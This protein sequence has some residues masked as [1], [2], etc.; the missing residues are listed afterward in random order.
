MLLK[1]NFFFEKS[2][3]LC[4]KDRE[5]FKYDKDVKSGGGE[6]FFVSKSLGGP[7]IVVIWSKKA[8]LY[9]PP[10]KYILL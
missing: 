3:H 10:K 1:S 2:A 7:I 9:M 8:A 6:Y 4:S 5:L